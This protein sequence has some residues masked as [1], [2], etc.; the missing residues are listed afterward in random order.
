MRY[1]TGTQWVAK[2]WS[3][4]TVISRLQYKKK[5]NWRVWRKQIDACSNALLLVTFYNTLVQA[6]AEIKLNSAS[7]FITQSVGQ[8]VRQAGSQSIRQ[9][10]RQ[11]DVRQISVSQTSV[12]HQSDLS[13]SDFSQTSVRFQSDFSQL[14]FSQTSVRPDRRQSDDSQTSVRR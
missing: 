14:D 6:E 5:G 2:N 4:L 13:Q 3:N 8:S 1:W 12:K 7:L 11:S 9:T 10:V